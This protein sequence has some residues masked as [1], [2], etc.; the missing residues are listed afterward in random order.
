LSPSYKSRAA[1]EDEDDDDDDDD[2]DEEE[3]GAF[4]PAAAAC[5][6]SCIGT[7]ENCAGAV[8]SSIGEN[9]TVAGAG[10]G[11]AASVVSSIGLF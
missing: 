7:D 9:K 10:A 1:D 5:V 11:A 3:N 6:D 4:S 2:E 8:V